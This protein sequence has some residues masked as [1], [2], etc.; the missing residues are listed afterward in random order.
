MENKLN[1]KKDL[2]QY[3]NELGKKLGFLI[4]SLKAS[5]KIKRAFL[6]IIEDF[7]LPQLER[8]AEI[9]ET[10]F[11]TEK[12]DFIEDELMEELTK[13]KEE[14]IKKEDELN[15]KTIKRLTI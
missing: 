6:E 4:A 9:L 1:E 13:I 10:K 2:E 3:A 8:L 5:D 11:L 14:T 12:T 15:L 7:S